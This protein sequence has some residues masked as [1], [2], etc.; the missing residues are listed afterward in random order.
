VIGI[1]VEA[2]V[3]RDRLP[4]APPPAPPPRSGGRVAPALLVRGVM[5][6]T[7]RT[8]PMTADV[9][10]VARLFLQEIGPLVL[11]GSDPGPGP[12][13]SRPPTLGTRNRMEGRCR[14]HPT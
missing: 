10:D 6:S 2:D 4:Q 8:V 3:L 14:H 12:G 1:V 9:A 5:T 7:A 13:R 11:P